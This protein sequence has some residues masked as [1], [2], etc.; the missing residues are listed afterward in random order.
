MSDE[1]DDK[2]IDAVIEALRTVIDPEL[3]VDIMTLGLVYEV[4]VGDGMAQVTFT[5]TTP[6][7]PMEHAIRGGIERAVAQVPGVDEVFPKLVWE[8]RWN[9]SFVKKGAL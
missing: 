3:G 7:C 5:L 8:P 4:G 9:P 6:G 2:T 1:E